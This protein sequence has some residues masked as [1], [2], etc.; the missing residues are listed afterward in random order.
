[1]KA[2]KLFGSS[3]LILIALLLVGGLTVSAVTYA[4]SILPSLG[5]S[6]GSLF[7]GLSRTGP[8]T[9]PATAGPTVSTDKLDYS[10]GEIVQISG[11]GFVGGEKVTW[12]S[13]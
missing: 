2:H 3:K 11:S 1:M 9:M 8:T 5:F 13:D 12:T 4:D 6:E 7:S 10:P